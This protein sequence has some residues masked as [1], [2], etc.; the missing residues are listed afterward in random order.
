MKRTIYL[1]HGK[2]SSDAEFANEKAPRFTQMEVPFRGFLL[3][4]L[5]AD[6]DVISCPIPISMVLY[7]LWVPPHAM[8]FHQKWMSKLQ[9]F[10]VLSDGGCQG[11]A[12]TTDA[13]WVPWELEL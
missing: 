10:E 2:Y 12:A 3:R 11:V 7:V 1:Q 9:G 8:F 4:I 5:K 6:K 13:N